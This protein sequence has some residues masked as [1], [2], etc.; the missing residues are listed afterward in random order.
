MFTSEPQIKEILYKQMYWKLRS[1][2]E[3][4]TTFLVLQG[5]ALWIVTA[6]ASSGMG[7]G[8]TG[9]FNYQIN[10]YGQETIFFM[11]VLWILL[12]GI[13]INTKAN[14]L[15]DVVFVTT[16]KLTHFSNI[17]LLLLFTAAASFI[18]VFTYYFIAAMVGILQS[19][20][21]T[22]FP[23][24]LDLGSSFLT[25]LA[26][27]F[28]FAAAGYF[29]GTLF[30]MSIIWR[31]LFGLFVFSILFVGLIPVTPVAAF[32]I[33]ADLLLLLVLSL[34]T[35]A[36]LFAVSILMFQPEGVRD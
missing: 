24:V 29:L 14:R 1:H 34:V 30:Q 36:I 16:A 33:E 5:I 2:S 10:E 12:S 4:V 31:I 22:D 3:I 28:F 20:V 13:L 6:N 19:G 18:S 9:S 21:V 25:W 17:A 11:T 27:L 23:G 26:Y 8:G 7:G 15:T 32:I 35:S